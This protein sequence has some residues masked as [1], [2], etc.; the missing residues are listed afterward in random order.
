MFKVKCDTYILKQNSSNNSNNNSHRTTNH[1]RWLDLRDDH[2]IIYRYKNPNNKYDFKK[3]NSDGHEVSVIILPSILQRSATRPTNSRK[4]EPVQDWKKENSNVSS[5]NIVDNINKE[6]IMAV[7]SEQ[8]ITT[9]H[10]NKDITKSR[11]NTVENPSDAVLRFQQSSKVVTKT[12]NTGNQVYKNDYE[13]SNEQTTIPNPIFES[14]SESDKENNNE[15]DRSTEETMS[16]DN[17]TAIAIIFK[18]L[19][20]LSQTNKLSN[21]PTDKYLY[22]EKTYHNDKPKTKI[23]DNPDCDSVDSK[24]Y[25]DN[26]DNSDIPREICNDDALML[27]VENKIKLKLV[28]NSNGRSSFQ[29]EDNSGRKLSSTIRKHKSDMDS[30]K[31]TEN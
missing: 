21:L 3:S 2:D 7:T 30:V 31:F 16:I 10:H 27:L 8:P 28:T 9:T 1:E 13:K 5:S 19:S 6:R 4:I 22:K 18:N 12:V 15:H 23:A 26:N 25:Q 20:L 17:K 29:E 11:N 14:E 24:E